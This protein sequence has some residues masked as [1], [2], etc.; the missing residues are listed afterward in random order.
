MHARLCVWALL[1]F[2]IGL[3][4]GCGPGDVGGPGD[5]V[6]VNGSGATG[7]S[8]GGTGTG[9]GGASTQQGFTVAVTPSSLTMGLDSSA[10]VLMEVM[11]EPGFESM[12]I[13]LF[14]DNLPAEVGVG[15]APDPLPHQGQSQATITVGPGAAA[16]VYE[17]VVGATA[18][19]VTN[20]TTLTLTVTTDVD[21]TVSA[22]PDPVTVAAGGSAQVVV[23]IASLNGFS[24]PVSLSAAGLPATVSATFNPASVVPPGASTLTL[25]ASPSAPLGATMF[26]VTGSGGGLDRS[27]SLTLNVTSP[28]TA[29]VTTVIGSTN[30]GNNCVLVG[31][32]RHNDPTERVYVGTVQTGRIW[33]LEWTG[34]SW[35]PGVNIGGSTS[36]NTELHNMNMGPGRNDGVMRIYAG[37]LSGAILEL[38]YQNGWSQQT[39]DMPGGSCTHTVVGP[40]RNDGVQRLYASCGSNVYEYTRSGNAWSRVTIGQVQSGIAHGLRL[41]PARQGDPAS[42]LYVATTGSSVYEAAYS[43]SWSLSRLVPNDTGDVRNVN[44]GVGRNDGVPRVYASR[45]NGLMSEY[46][47]TG[48]AWSRQDLNASLNVVLVHAYVATARDDSL[49]R[50]YSSAGDGNG[51]EFAWGGA[52][53]S[54]TTLGGGSGYMYGSSIGNPR[55][56]KTRFYAASFNTNVYEYSWE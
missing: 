56:D 13:D 22:Q 35:S 32:G 31:P 34:N 21:F 41:G 20:T 18:E 45:A 6:T 27:D 40:G 11:F 4:A 42:Y 8:G 33:E 26:S 37:L 46:S 2:T 12:S 47:W 10:T 1:L 30:D 19:G 53:W 28:G 38:T 36:G 17:L 44:F 39:V 49:F 52:S 7:A 50:V 5:A 48:S 15:F 16:G 43:S 23:N 14:A 54:V 3:L 51:Y 25:S 9:G 24:A 55:G 29:W